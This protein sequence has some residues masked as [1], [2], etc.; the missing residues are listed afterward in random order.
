MSSEVPVQAQLEAYNLK[1]LD[2][3]VAQYAHNV[4]IHDFPSLNL[5]LEGRE[6]LRAFFRDH[7][8]NIENLHADLINRIVQ[9]KTVIDHERVHGMKE[10]PVYVIAIYEVDN[11][12][13]QNVWFIR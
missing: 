13:I 12:L 4:K 7:R 2:N 6:N 8:F 3:F 1:D 11:N 10:E 9:G 5:T